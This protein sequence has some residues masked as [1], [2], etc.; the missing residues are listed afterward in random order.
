MTFCKD[1]DDDDVVVGVR[2]SVFIVFVVFE[3]E[4][5][6]GTEVDDGVTDAYKTC[7][8]WP[9]ATETFGAEFVFVCNK[10][11]VLFGNTVL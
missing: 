7:C 2:V 10:R 9:F 6:G 11:G 4:G 1:D 8:P 5:N 3:R